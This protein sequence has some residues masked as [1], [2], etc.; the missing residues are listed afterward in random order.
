MEQNSRVAEA[1][2]RSTRRRHRALGDVVDPAPRHHLRE[3]RVM[4]GMQDAVQDAARQV[5]R[6]ADPREKRPLGV[7]GVRR[8]PALPFED[9]R[10]EV[11]QAFKHKVMRGKSRL[12]ASRTTFD[13]RNVS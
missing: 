1:A 8:R 9:P 4:Y 12:S 5:T 2:Y 6:T 10:R 7:Q 13:T 3:K 11:N